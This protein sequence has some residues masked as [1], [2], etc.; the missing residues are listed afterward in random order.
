MEGASVR[1]ETD[2]ITL[3]LNGQHLVS[4]TVPRAGGPDA[5]EVHLQ[6]GVPISLLVDREAL[7]EG[8]DDGDAAL[9][10]PLPVEADPLVL[11]CRPDKVV[12]SRAFETE[13]G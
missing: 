13:V 7:V 5:E 12:L 4:T 2:S 6:H 10:I 9:G 8:E 11:I 3:L 1:N